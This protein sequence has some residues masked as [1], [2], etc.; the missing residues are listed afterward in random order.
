MNVQRAAARL[1]REWQ[2]RI[3]SLRPAREFWR[4]SPRPLG[5]TQGWKIHVAASILTANKIFSRVHPILE[6]HQSLFK[7]PARLDDL[8]RLNCGLPHFSQVGKFITIYP[9]STVE[10]VSLARQLHQAT[11]GLPGPEVPYDVCYR[12]GSAVFYRYGV[13]RKRGPDSDP[14]FLVDPAGRKRR[15]RRAYGAAVPRWL[16]DPFQPSPKKRWRCTA[17]IGVDFLPFKALMQRGKG[18][19]YEALD[20][21]VSPARRVIIKEGHRHGETAWDGQDGY[22]R[23]RRE[24]RVL[25]ALRRAGLPVPKVIREFVQNGRRYLVLEKISGRPLIG[26][27]RQHPARPSW[28]RAQRLLDRLGPLLS[29]VHKAGW[30]WRDC[31]P[32]HIFMHRGVMRLIDFEGA[33]RLDDT[34]ALSWS[35][36]NYVPPI[37][38]REFSRRAGTMEDHYALGVIAFQFL[39][40]EFPSA[41]NRRRARC[42]KRA[43]CPD[44]LRTKIEALLGL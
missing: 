33:C 5:P 15:D 30:V 6:R 27:K 25:H 42:Y 29:Q 44:S 26:R 34:Q 38:E 28:R 2:S 13:F 39:A 11:R 9:S 35:S 10:A 37:Y 24:A 1:E 21:S 18:G 22:T 31:K 4:Y 8:R 23:V 16:S 43:G 40:G 32:A 7:V 41:D 14:S 19:V 36:P 17:P 20:L 12:R 3:H